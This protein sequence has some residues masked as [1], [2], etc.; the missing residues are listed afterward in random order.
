MLVDCGPVP[1][2]VVCRLNS[3]TAAHQWK[4]AKILPHLC[5]SRSME[6]IPEVALCSR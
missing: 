1:L 5:A 2:N 3:V 6:A 4:A